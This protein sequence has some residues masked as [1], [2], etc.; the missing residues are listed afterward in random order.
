MAGGVSTYDAMM[1]FVT[2]QLPKY[3]NDAVI[4]NAMREACHQNLYSI[5]NSAGM[6]GV[7]ADTVI[8]KTD[9]HLVKILRVI[10]IGLS[11]LFILSLVMWMVKRHKFKKTEG[12]YK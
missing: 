12:S 11:L 5:A 6:N 4:V 8:K 3:K 1:P 2:K 9:I 7:G 10:G